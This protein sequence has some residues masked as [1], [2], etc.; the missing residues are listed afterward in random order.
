MS[1]K[2][3][4]LELDGCNMS[5]L[6]FLRYLPR[7]EILSLSRCENITDDDL[8]AIKYVPKLEQLY[9]SHMGLSA[10]QVLFNLTKHRLHNLYALDCQ[11]VEFI[12]TEALTMM[13]IQ[14][15]LIFF[16]LSLFET[17]TPHTFDNTLGK[18]FPDTEFRIF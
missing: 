10:S 8:S 2:L 13:V 18:W 3:Q 16:G 17:F 9:I 12:F 5:T 11:G 1:N 7:L 4:W 15:H 6:S 14:K